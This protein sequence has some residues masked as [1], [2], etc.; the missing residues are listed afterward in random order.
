MS[1]RSTD[2]GEEGKVSTKANVGA[3]QWDEEEKEG[4]GG[5]SCYIPFMCGRHAAQQ[6]TSLV[7][8]EWWECHFCATAH[9]CAQPAPALHFGSASK[10][11]QPP[12]SWLD[13]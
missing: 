11:L 12:L 8:A 1:R 5:P 9:Q 7:V 6:G 4:K 2:N 13:T 10:L 3:Q